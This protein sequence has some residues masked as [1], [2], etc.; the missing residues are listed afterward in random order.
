MKKQLFVIVFVIFSLQI[1]AQTGTVS[2]EVLSREATVKI[3]SD[4]IKQK[5]NI[6]YPIYRVYKCTDL[7]GLFYVVLTESGDSL[8]PNNDTVNKSIRALKITS[9]KNGLSKSWEL[10]DFIIK[11][12]YGSGYESSLF[13]WPR[14]NEYTDLDGDNLIDPLV[15]Y[16]TSGNDGYYDGRIKIIIYHK[17][18]KIAIRHQNSPMDFERNT[19]VDKEFYDL[20]LK[21]QNKVK[22]IMLR[23]EDDNRAIFPAGWQEAMK[24]KE[25]KFDEN[26]HK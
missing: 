23:M 7:T 20:P 24:R 10:N 11:L 13:F 3:F 21:I 14:Y 17:G 18:A 1:F 2:T 4:S 19:Q 12:V 8:T 5:L 9:T 6:T 25:L 22:E 15:I 26:H 16:G